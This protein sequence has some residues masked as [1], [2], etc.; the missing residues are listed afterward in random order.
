MTQ[1]K[2]SSIYIASPEGDTGKSTV[3]LGVMHRLAAS[4]ARVGVFRPIAR[5][6]ESV[7]YILELLLE[8]STADIAY[9]DCLGVSY[10]DVHQDPDA[11]I[12]Q[13]VDRYHAVA[14]RC[15]AVVIVGSDYTDVASPS[16]LGTNARIAVNLGAPVLLTIK[17]FDRTPD[18]V[19][20]LAEV[21]LGE[22]K[23]QRAHTAAIV[24]NRC[25]P[26][27]LDE[28][29]QAL[30][31]FD[32]PA[33]VLPEVPLLVS[34]S[35][36][37]LMKAV[38]GSLVSGD[39]ALLSREATS[40]MVAGMT[41]EHCLERLKEGQAV[42]F[43]ADRSDVLLAVAS[44]HVAEGFPSLSAIILNGGLKLHPRIADL[45]DGIGLRLP[46]IETDS[47]TFE[48]ASAA[49]HARGRVTVASARKIDTA[50]ALMDR[51]VDGADL[52]AQLAI[53]IPSVTTP[54][55][56]EYQL[57]DRARDNRKRIVLPEGDDD[58]ILK[59]AGRL[60]QR[61]VAD[62][63]IL[64]EE[65]EI[66]SRAAELGVDISNALVV[67]PKT[68]DLAE[69]FADQ[70]FELR[71]HKGMTPDRAREIMRNVS[72][73][74]TMLV[75]NDIVDGMVSGAA[76]TTAHTIRPAFEVIRTTSGVSTVSSI[77]LMCLADRVLAYGDCAIVPDPTS[78]QLADIAISSARTAAQFGID[79]R[80]AML[81]YSTGS[82]GSGADVE[83]VRIATELVRSRQ[84]E[85]LVEGPI[86]YDAAVEPS[87]AATK[88][89]DSPVAGRA[90]VLIFPDLNTGN[91][92]YKAVQRSAG[93]VAIGPVLQGLRKPINDLSRGALVEDIVNTVAITAIQAQ[94]RKQS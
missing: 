62:L 19:A 65:A 68:S 44:A 41:A 57:L 18:E 40:F 12:A 17:G 58:R 36:E 75:Y 47:G 78:E 79:P 77:F 53:P 60:L 34:P 35:V 81:S 94:E 83:K 24:A 39:E 38:K 22:L 86:Q 13:I 50:L 72:Y 82:S 3:A 5:S 64:G 23:A 89:P 31:R 67:S 9:E 91:N 16:E 6:G 76:H 10:H 59:A 21:C 49:A 14:E 45:V 88:M 70:Y 54:Q 84:P 90:T 69:K 7:D 28:V 1:P 46:I 27:Q 37:E 92:T 26:D 71:K 30:A 61:Q 66:R 20:A 73:F 80:V 48:T 87:V 25:N 8:Q 51:Y 11:A 93:A 33:W 85:L 74:G 29:R 32:K 15:D 42:I 55:M 56:F 43:P 63:T 2:A 52:V 4:V